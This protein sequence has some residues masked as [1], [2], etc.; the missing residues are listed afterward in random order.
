MKTEIFGVVLQI[1]IPVLLAYPLGKY[2]AKVYKGEKVFTD[3]L[4]PLERLIY[5]AGGV[6][7][8]KE[9]DWKKFLKTLLILNIVW[10][11]WGFCI[12]VITGS[13]TP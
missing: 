13:V 4:K 3:F 6:N 2:I 8:E 1:L 5:K 9:M 11:F 10:F 7:P 12:A